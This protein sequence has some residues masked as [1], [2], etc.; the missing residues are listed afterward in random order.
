MRK[1]I[2]PLIA[3]VLLIAFTISV[4]GLFGNWVP[5]LI[6]GVQEDVSSSSESIVDASDMQI[7]ITRASY[8]P[9]SGN[10]SVS[11][12]NRGD[13]EVAN[14]TATAYADTPVQKEVDVALKPGEI[15]SFDISVGSNPD[16]LSVDLEDYPVADKN[17]D[18][19]SASTGEGTEDTTDP[20]ISSFTPSDG[21]SSVA[22]DTSFNFTFSEEVEKD[23]GDFRLYNV[24]GTLIETIDVNNGDS[25]G[26]KLVTSSTE[27]D[28][29]EVDPSISLN[30]STEYYW[31]A[32]SGVLQDTSG[33]SWNGISDTTTYN[34][35]SKTLVMADFETGD[36]SNWDNVP[37]SW[38][39]ETSTVYEGNYAFYKEAGNGP[40]SS[41]TYGGPVQTPSQGDTFRWHHY[42]GGNS[43]GASQIQFG[44][45]DWN[46]RYQASFNINDDVMKLQKVEGGSGSTMTS[47]SLSGSSGNWYI[48]EVE[49][50]EDGT[51]IYTVYD[52]NENQLNQISATDNTFTSGGIALE[53][54]GDVYTDNIRYVN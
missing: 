10:L 15:T 23:S 7:D 47:S 38:S 36:F 45:Q 53:A 8:N 49:W 50:Q 48:N 5:N 22:V 32:D 17:S 44:F 16:S 2:S 26:V 35:T 31:Q 39:I 3:A 41:A 24:S 21:A 42:H 51:I 30:E 18:I 4:A 28:T 13:V 37:S 29:A 33:N 11:V 19:N 27:N 14:L 46:N 25:G 34:F 12:T 6:G 40:A 20:V 52:S 43:N 9:D 1:G 54:H